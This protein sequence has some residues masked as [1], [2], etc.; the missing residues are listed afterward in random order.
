LAFKIAL[1]QSE[2]PSK[3][4]SVTSQNIHDAKGI[5]LRSVLI[6][7]K[8][9]RKSLIINMAEPEGFEPSVRF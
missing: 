9:S 7:E 2:I 4:L 6:F 5:V 1:I 8:F 3:A